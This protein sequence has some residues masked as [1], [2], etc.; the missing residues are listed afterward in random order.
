MTR[1]ERLRLEVSDDGE[2]DEVV[3]YLTLP[4]RPED[5]VGV[6]KRQVRLRDL[7]KDYVGPDLYFDFDEDNTLL[8]IEILD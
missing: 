5:P 3:A 7:I 8:G 4:D 2:D 1:R 6:V